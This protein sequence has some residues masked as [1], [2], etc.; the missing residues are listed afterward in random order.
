[1]RSLEDIIIIY[2][3]P[4]CWPEASVALNLLKKIGQWITDSLFSDNKSFF[5]S[6]KMNN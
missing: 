3:Q 1:M 4:K 2:I 6:F 5:A